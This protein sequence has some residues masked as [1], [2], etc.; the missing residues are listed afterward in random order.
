[1][2]LIVKWKEKLKSCKS[3]CAD[4]EHRNLHRINSSTYATM[5]PCRASVIF[6]FNVLNLYFSQFYSIVFGNELYVCRQTHSG[7]RDTN[8]QRTI[9][10]SKIVTNFT[11]VCGLASNG[12]WTGWAFQAS[13]HF[14]AI[15]LSREELTERTTSFEEKLSLEELSHKGI[16]YVKWLLLNLN[17]NQTL[18][19]KKQN[20]SSARHTSGVAIASIAIFYTNFE[21]DR[22]SWPAI[23]P[24][25]QQTSPE[26]RRRKNNKMHVTW[27]ADENY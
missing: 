3:S 14:L 17:L 21:I 5:P 2:R 6:G 13:H 11:E 18:V 12:A 22:D 23:G 1:M 20:S 7:P 9:V 27:C 25:W 15:A 16:Y 4:C 24:C 8:R 26:Q 10:L 19:R